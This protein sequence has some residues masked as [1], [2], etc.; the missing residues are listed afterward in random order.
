MNELPLQ[1]GL[2]N[3]SGLQEAVNKLFNLDVWIVEGLVPQSAVEAQYGSHP[4]S[5]NKCNNAE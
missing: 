2:F 4:E 5:N 3:L 1:P